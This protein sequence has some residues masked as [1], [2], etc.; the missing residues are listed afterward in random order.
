[1]TEGTSWF[2]VV[3]FIKSLISTIR[4]EF[5][6]SDHLLKVPLVNIMPLGIRILT[7]ELGEKRYKHAK[8]SND[9]IQ[10]T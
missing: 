8:Q 4:A 5:S 2:S 9:L 6:Q 10:N 3:F 1:M 7:Y